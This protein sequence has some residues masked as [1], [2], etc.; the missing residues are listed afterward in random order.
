MPHVITHLR[1]VPPSDR[2]Y[3]E[4]QDYEFYEIVDHALNH[5]GHIRFSNDFGAPVTPPSTS[6]PISEQLP[7]S[8]ELLFRQSIEFILG[9]LNEAGLR[10]AMRQLLTIAKDPN[11]S[12]TK[13]DTLCHEDEPPMAQD[14]S[15]AN[16]Q[17]DAGNADSRSE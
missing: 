12:N 10:E 13:E 15:R 14:Y 9:K 2:V 16:A 11:Y 5:P 7:D 6:A 1:F 8:D 3:S 17:T 4:V